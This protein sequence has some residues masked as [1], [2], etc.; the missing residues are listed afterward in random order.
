MPLATVPSRSARHSRRREE[1]RRE[2]HPAS[3]PRGRGRES[4]GDFDLALAARTTLGRRALPVRTATLD[5]AHT[6]QGGEGSL[7]ALAFL[8]DQSMLPLKDLALL[9][10]PDVYYSL[11]H[12]LDIIHQGQEDRQRHVRERIPCHRQRHG[13]DRRPQGRRSERPVQAR[14]TKGAGRGE[15]AQEAAAPGASAVPSLLLSAL[16]AHPVVGGWTVLRRTS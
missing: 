15:R 5:E 6:H 2:D 9:R 13:R 4:G 11:R 8:T 12:V 14:P 16:L 10:R 7:F 1:A 3:P